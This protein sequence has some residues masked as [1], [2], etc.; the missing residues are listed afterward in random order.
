MLYYTFADGRILN[1]L[2]TSTSAP[3]KVGVILDRQKTKQ[4]QFYSTSSG[5]GSNIEMNSVLSVIK[6]PYT[7]SDG[8]IETKPLLRFHFTHF[9]KEIQTRNF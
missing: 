2:E 7:Q 8:K 6:Y 3:R 1:K 5:V 4:N 9:A